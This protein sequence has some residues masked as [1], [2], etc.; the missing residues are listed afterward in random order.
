MRALDT[1]VL[2]QA[3]VVTSP[4]HA[5]A[6]TLLS[7]L[8]EGRAPWAI[9]WPCVYEFLRVVTHPRIFHPPMPSGKALG[10]LRQI[11]ASP[12]WWCLVKPRGIQ[13]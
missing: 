10:D 3:E 12:R 11:L 5:V 2:V 4:F 7:D 13:R 1:N 6:R 9:P 8:A